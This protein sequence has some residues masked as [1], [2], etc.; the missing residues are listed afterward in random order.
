MRFRSRVAL[1]RQPLATWRERVRAESGGLARGEGL[2]AR[3]RMAPA[4]ERPEIVRE[5]LDG[6]SDTGET[7]SLLVLR[8]LAIALARGV[9]LGP[10]ETAGIHALLAR[11]DGHPSALVQ[12][13]LVELLVASAAPGALDAVLARLDRAT[14]Q[15]E[16]IHCVHALVRFPGPWTPDAHRRLLAW[17]ARARGYR[18]GHL[19][20]QIVARM[21]A[22]LLATL[23]EGE[24][25][26]LAAEIALLESP[27][28]EAAPPRQARPFVKH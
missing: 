8:V 19:L 20:S 13:E 3:V 14:S 16:E 18:G 28:G 7:E 9:T 26:D 2:L 22:D 11:L 21:Q 17:F 25:S 24:R 4:E 6:A 1:E 27:A 5:A 12:R 15:E 23:V 10:D